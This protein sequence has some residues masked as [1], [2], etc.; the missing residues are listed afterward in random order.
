MQ[1]INAQLAL[2]LQV[3]LPQVEAAVRLLEE[4]ASVPFIARYRNEATAGLDDI[5]LRELEQR[6]AYLRK[7]EQ[8][9]AA[10]LSSV[11]A[12]GKLTPELRQALLASAFARLKA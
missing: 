3:R 9:R 12:Q 2:E 6:L 5:A 1:H 4:G 11:Q 7:L 8:R 10:V